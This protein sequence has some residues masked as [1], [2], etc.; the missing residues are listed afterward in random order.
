MY[1]VGNAY[2]RYTHG[3]TSQRAQITPAAGDWCASCGFE[4]VAGCVPDAAVLHI[5]T[6]IGCANRTTACCR[7]SSK[8]GSM[9]GT[10]KF[11]HEKWGCW[12]LSSTKRGMQPLLPSN[13]ESIPRNRN[14]ACRNPR[15]L[16]WTVLTHIL[17]PSW[18]QVSVH[19]GKRMAQL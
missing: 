3:R 9:L 8:Y 11:E 12:V 13:Q 1:L 10:P 4:A 17:L 5:S 19:T 16:W 6:R 2:V 7:R 15:S 18:E 14:G